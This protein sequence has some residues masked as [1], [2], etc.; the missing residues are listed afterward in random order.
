MSGEFQISGL[1]LAVLLVVVMVLYLLLRRLRGVLKRLPIAAR[2]RTMIRK[3]RPVIELVVLVG[4]VA[5]SVRLVFRGD[6]L[7]GTLVLGLIVLGAVLLTW[8]WLRDL[9]AG[10]MIKTSEVVFPGDFIEVDGISGW[11]VSRGYRVIELNTAEG[12]QVFVP[13]GKIATSTL[14]RK[15]AADGNFRHG[16]EVEIPPDVEDVELR[17][18]IRRRV[19]YAHWTSAVREPQI[20]VVRDGIMK[21]TVFSVGEGQGPLIERSVRKAL[22]VWLRDR[23]QGAQPSSARR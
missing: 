11:V 12:D 2:H 22:R 13:Y 16:F 19:L 17:G 3:A 20:R 7:Y 6:P 14:V 8:S 5:L 23:E 10:L 18:V 4:F 1:N 21:V 15:P 9:L